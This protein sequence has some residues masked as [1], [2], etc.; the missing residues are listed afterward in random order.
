[1]ARKVLMMLNARYP[2]D[3]RVKKEAGALIRAGV[4]VHLLS[5][6]GKSDAAQEV[7]DGIHV[8][9]IRAGVNNYELAFWD[10]VMSVYQVHPKFKKAARAILEE[11]KISVVHVHDLPLAATALS[12]KKSLR[13][14]VV[15]D[16]HEN[17]PDALRT[18]FQWK[19]N[20]VAR[21]KNFLFL[22]PERWSRFEALAS[23][24]ADR[25][26]AVVDEMK[27]RLIREH[28]LPAEKIVVV[29]NT[30]DKSFADQTLDA[31]IYASLQGKFIVTYSGG[32]G[33]HRGVDVAIQA[34][35]L[36]R[37]FPQIHLAIVGSGSPAVMQRLQAMKE[38][39]SLSNVHFMGYQSFQYFFSIM[40]FANVNII[41]HQSN[42]HTDNTVPHKLFQG[43]MA[44][45]PL[46]VSSSAPLKR[47]VEACH[48]GLV[49]EA[50]SPGDCAAK[51][52]ALYKDPELCAQLGANG[53]RAT[54][55]GNLNWEATQEELIALYKTLLPA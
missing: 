32:V 35:E 48:S 30:E 27:V 20:L 1:M 33:P 50:G 40:H 14:T 31:S 3:I 19:T 10:V 47:I 39:A 53:R 23:K 17:Y 54:L 2:A 52:K 29:T 51:I 46:L 28:G 38:E 41:P 8:H 18:W 34:M 22:N 16:F 42:G 12:L 36:L 13:L 49:F 7:V 21:L 15:V 44:G 25:I 26:I 5:L 11:E 24:Q 45:R 43:M 55:E 4:E 37:E 9:R 6:R